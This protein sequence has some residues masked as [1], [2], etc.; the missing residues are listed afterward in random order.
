MLVS[1]SIHLHIQ[2]VCKVL[3]FSH[4]AFLQIDVI[5]KAIEHQLKAANAYLKCPKEKDMNM[6]LSTAYF[7]VNKFL[8]EIVLALQKFVFF[9]Y[10][11]V[12][13]E[14]FSCAFHEK[15]I[16]VFGD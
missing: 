11:A 6:I 9:Y 12:V 16:V 4:G 7:K 1:F 13:E 15:V 14:M 10:D 2:S 8:E 5:Y 3:A